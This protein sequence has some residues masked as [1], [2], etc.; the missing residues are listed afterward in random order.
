MAIILPELL[1]QRRPYALESL[2]QNKDVLTTHFDIH[3]TILDVLNLK[4][5]SNKYKIVGADLPRAMTLLEPV[6]PFYIQS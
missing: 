5:K 3:A 2:K 1:K 6:W 4:H